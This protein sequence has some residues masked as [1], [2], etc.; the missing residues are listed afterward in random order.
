MAN[1][2]SLITL[3]TREDK[4]D[5]EGIPYTHPIPQVIRLELFLRPYIKA[6][7]HDFY[8]T[9][10]RIFP[11]KSWRIAYYAKWHDYKTILFCLIFTESFNRCNLVMHS[12][13]LTNRLNWI[14][15]RRF[16]RCASCVVFNDQ[17]TKIQQLDAMYM[18]RFINHR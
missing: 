9:K 7:R 6:I 16:S 15:T 11:E 2:R 5:R 12:V 10:P 1:W 8:C 14:A 17:Q 13:L 4:R 18:M 3:V